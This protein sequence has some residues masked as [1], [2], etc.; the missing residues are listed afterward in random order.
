MVY[1]KIKNYK[2][3]F[4]DVG[5]GHSIYYELSGNPDGKPVLFIHGGPGAGFFYQD[6]QFFNPKIFNIITFDQR[7]AGKSKPFASLD[8]NNTNLLVND[9]N[10]LLTMLHI[11]RVFLFGGSWGS[12]LSLVYA[13]RNP[14]RVAAMV[15]RGIFLASKEEEE[16]M[17]YGARHVFPEV[18]ET[19]ARLVPD[20]HKKRILEFFYEM[21]L[22]QDAQIRSKFARAWETYEISISKL[23]YSKRVVNNFLKM[24]K[25]EASARIELHYLVNQC[26]IPKD[27][28][29][30][31][32]EKLKGIP[33]SIVHGRYDHVASPLSAYMLH[34]KLPD[35]SLYYTLAGH[36]AYDTDTTKRLVKEMDKLGG[37]NLI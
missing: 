26:F 14:D 25:Y 10:K 2:K 31:N 37:R 23:K 7:G 33:V 28:I 8:N 20:S 5:E 13:I 4:L 32:T 35:S 27:Y 15:L 1:K 9:I 19:M 3:G 36:S 24:I 16:Y 29:L 17:F 22:S 6:K 34:K 30:R 21:V 12:T 18:W 11:D